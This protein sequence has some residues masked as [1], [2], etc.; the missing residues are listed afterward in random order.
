ML[1]SSYAPPNIFAIEH[2][3]QHENFGQPMR[4]FS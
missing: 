3:G 1:T 2:L 4:T